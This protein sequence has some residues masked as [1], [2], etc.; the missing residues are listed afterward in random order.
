MTNPP[1]AALGRRLPTTPWRSTSD[2]NRALGGHIGVL[3]AIS[4]FEVIVQSN[5]VYAT[6][7]LTSRS[8]QLSKPMPSTSNDLNSPARF[9]L[10]CSV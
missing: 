4:C 10:G 9:T 1:G 6:F 7:T 3:G 2:A 8:R 5:A